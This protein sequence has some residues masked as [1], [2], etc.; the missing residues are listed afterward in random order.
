MLTQAKSPFQKTTAV[1]RWLA[2]L[3]LCQL[4]F[5]I[6]YGDE[7]SI[8][9][10][11]TNQLTPR[12]SVSP[13]NTRAKDN[14]EPLTAERRNIT[15]NHS[16]SSAV[17]V[18]TSS[19]RPEFISTTTSTPQEQN[20]TRNTATDAS[21]DS[22]IQSDK[23][24]ATLQHIHD[25]TPKQI[26]RRGTLLEQ[27]MPSA[28]QFKGGGSIL[29]P[30]RQ[31]L[32]SAPDILTA[33]KQRRQLT[34]KDLTIVSRKKLTALGIILSTYRVPKGI[35]IDN[36]IGQLQE[37]FPDA[38]VEQNQR[39]R[40]LSTEDR[41]ID[42]RAYGQVMVGLQVPSQCLQ[43]I[44]LAMLDSAVS[45]DFISTHSDRLRL[46]NVTS[47]ATPP[48]TH[49]TAIA[50]L[51]MSDI[52]VYPGLLP[53]A[54]LDVINIFVNDKNGDPET[55]TDWLLYGLNLLAGFNPPP[56]AVNLS[57]GGHHSVLLETALQKLSK[58]M[59]F[60]AAAG[61]DGT[62]ALVYPAAYET[63]YAVGAVDA[64]GRFTRPTNRGTH[65]ELIAPGEDI[66][67]LDGQGHGFYASGTSFATPFATAALALL[68]VRNLTAS[69][70]IESLGASHLVSFRD[71]CP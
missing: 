6:A 41:I 17:P 22:D 36:L 21:R 13:E 7:R 68:K 49:G 25:N 62:H 10:A 71:L 29:P 70:Y 26:L 38:S 45:P 31:I 56:E 42:K 8:N 54:S 37:W 9:L 32:L 34:Q 16:V 3:L 5:A 64:N 44:R 1:T 46:F 27:S 20:N 35:D 28:P 67:T 30:L 69:E 23:T 66:W 24:S 2:V 47:S 11:P 43:P 40:L 33:E 55:R 65:V 4:Q 51:L 48:N 19:S 39:F 18:T 57:F 58:T 50:S 60:A 53:L 61:N 52:A 59:H 63:V 15:L 14:E 12:T